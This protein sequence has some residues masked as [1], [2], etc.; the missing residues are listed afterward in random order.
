VLY[1]LSYDRHVFSFSSI[2]TSDARIRQAAVWQH[3]R[4]TFRIR[5]SQRMR[6]TK[7]GHA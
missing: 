7:C 4:T 3:R 5:R 2:K 1:Q 6:F